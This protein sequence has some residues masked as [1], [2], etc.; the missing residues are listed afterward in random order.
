MPYQGSNNT[1]VEITQLE[2]T[3][4]Q[5][6]IIWHKTTWLKPKRKNTLSRF[7][8]HTNLDLSYLFIITM[9]CPISSKSF[10]HSTLFDIKIAVSVILVLVNT[11]SIILHL[12]LL[13][14]IFMV[15][16][17]FWHCFLLGL[18]LNNLHCST[19]LTLW[20]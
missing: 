9:K 17:A 19:V 1:Q 18:L 3:S 5:L 4:T 6:E 13:C 20:R 11:F 15:S 10:C 2:I 7:T 8:G 12:T 14:L 16:Q